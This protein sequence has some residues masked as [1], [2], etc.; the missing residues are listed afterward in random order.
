MAMGGGKK[1]EGAV[2]AN[3]NV[4]PMIDVMLV[5]LIIF[6]IVTPAITAGF[7]ATIPRAKNPDAREEGEGEIRLGIDRDGK[8]YI[9]ITDPRTGKYTGPKFVADADLQD[10][11]TNLYAARTVDKI[12]YLKADEGIEYSRIQVALEIARKAGVRVVGAIAEQERT[13]KPES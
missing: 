7:Q 12:M 11:L 2:A 6:M 13:K 10:R 8:F 1:A 9:D 5:L 4:T 3:I